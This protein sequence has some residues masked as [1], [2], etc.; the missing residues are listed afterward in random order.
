MLLLILPGTISIHLDVLDHWHLQSS[1]LVD[2]DGS[3]I[4]TVGYPMKDWYPVQ[5]PCTVLACLMQNGLHTNLFYSTN[6]KDISSEPFDHSWWYRVEFAIPAWNSGKIARL[7]FQGINYRANVWLNGE[8]LGTSDQIVGTFRYFDFVKP[9]NF[10][11]E[12]GS[13]ALAVEV[14]RPHNQV[15]NDSDVEIDLAITFV[16]WAPAP[17]DSNM[18]L[19]G[20]VLLDISDP[21]SIRYPAVITNLDQPINTL[22]KSLTAHLTV[23]AEISNIGSESV[24]GVLQGSITLDGK[25]IVNNFEQQLSLTSGQSRQV[26][27]SSADYPAL[28]V[29]NPQLWWPWQMGN[30]VLHTLTLSF[31]PDDHAFSNLAA[32]TWQFG[33]RSVSS[34]LD[35]NQNHCFRSMVATYFSEV[36]DGH[37]T[38]Y[39]DEI[40]LD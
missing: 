21:V 19:F 25:S 18:G 1:N 20:P 5:V 36:V 28:V 24:S 4:S 13:M 2:E 27:F 22:N 11:T 34:K 39:Y 30:P 26:V 9:V 37:L 6:M 8:Q 3:K 40:Y 23:M 7:N 12:E 32:P 10:A 17:P 15:Y 31:K 16:D 35:H 14:F 29:S 33:I 38:Y